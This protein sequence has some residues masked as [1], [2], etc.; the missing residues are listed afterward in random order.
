VATHSSSTAIVIHRSAHLTTGAA[1]RTD[2]RT[3]ATRNTTIALTC[4]Q[5]LALGTPGG[6]G[7]TRT[8][9]HAPSARTST[10]IASVSTM[11]SIQADGAAAGTRDG[12]KGLMQ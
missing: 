10:R 4:M 1:R 5:S 9:P 3:L 2:A 11:E 12:G 7:R 6:A 8:A